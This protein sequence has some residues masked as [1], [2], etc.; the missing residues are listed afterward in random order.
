MGKKDATPPLRYVG[1]KSKYVQFLLTKAPK[2]GVFSEYR[3]P[4]VG[5]GALFLAFRKA[6]PMVPA[7]VN[8]I[9]EDLVSFWVSLR[10]QPQQLVERV[11][12]LKQRFPNGRQL[13]EYLTGEPPKDS[14]ER[15]AAFFVLNRITYSGLGRAGGYS[16]FAFR[17]RFTEQSIR[18]LLRVAPYLEG[19]RVTHGDYEE[20][21]QGC[22]FNT[23]VYFD[24]PYFG[25]R[26]SKLYGKRGAYHVDFDHERLCRVV[27][28]L[29]AFVMISYD[30]NEFV[31]N[32][33]RGWNITV[34]EPSYSVANGSG[35]RTRN[36]RELVIR[37]YEDSFGGFAYGSVAR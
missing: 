14:I 24:P 10:D 13:H 28:S 8:D 15:G 5:G 31:R 25:N 17:E 19:V 20:A 30:D 1:G 2:W 26:A 33:Y 27:R 12:W 29:S 4:M 9:D 21:L 22:K 23:F 3:E 36:K 7:W 32:A 6:Y 37:N 16:E 34:W 35:K 18:N 11:Y